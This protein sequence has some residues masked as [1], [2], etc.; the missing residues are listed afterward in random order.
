M[1]LSSSKAHPKVT[2][3]APMPV[4]EHL[5]TLAA[6]YRLPS[7]LGEPSL[8]PPATAEWG[9]PTFHFELPPLRETW[10]GR[11]AAEKA[12]QRK[13]DL[14]LQHP[15]PLFSISK[16]D[17]LTHQAA[18]STAASPGAGYFPQDLPLRGIRK[19]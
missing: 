16:N 6:P 10:Y 7:V 15:P 4:G 2:K 8:H 3:V 14:Q 19:K 17:F 11:A 5:P 12:M 1:G 18:L 9:E 13:E